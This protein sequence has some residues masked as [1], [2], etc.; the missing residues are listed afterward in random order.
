MMEYENKSGLAK[1]KHQVLT[2]QEQNGGA[3]STFPL[4]FPAYLY[5]VEEVP[6]GDCHDALAAARAAPVDG[7]ERGVDVD[8]GVDHGLAVPECALAQARH[9]KGTK[10]CMD[11]LTRNFFSW[12]YR[13]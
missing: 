13:E 6:W 2:E 3:G 12:L 5:E 10:T 1:N 9:L 11:P 8:H 4:H 7:V